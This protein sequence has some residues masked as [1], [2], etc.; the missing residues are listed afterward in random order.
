[1]RLFFGLP[2]GPEARRAIGTWIDTFRQNFSGKKISWVKPELLH[3]TLRFLGETPPGDLEKLAGWETCLESVSAIPI[4]IGQ[5]DGFPNL[6]DP[7]VL[8]LHVSPVEPVQDVYRRLNAY[9]SKLGISA[10]SR[11]YVPHLTIA[12]IRRPIPRQPTLS[13]PLKTIQDTLS[14]VTLFESQLTP[15]GPIHRA[16]SSAT[17]RN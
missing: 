15:S 1:M 13:S 3:V 5:L 10:E 6:R 14:S 7:K 11:P 16:I 12:R 17:L 8:F 4:I 2:I 9:L